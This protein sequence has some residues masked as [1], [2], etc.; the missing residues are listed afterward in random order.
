MWFFPDDPE[1][2]EMRF[3]GGLERTGLSPSCSGIADH[4]L[5]TID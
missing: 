5:P 4:R 1:L 3:I 2:V